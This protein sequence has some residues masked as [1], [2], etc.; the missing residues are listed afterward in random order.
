[1]NDEDNTDIDNTDNYYNPKQF[2]ANI[3]TSL[4]DFKQKF[5]SESKTRRGL[6]LVSAFFAVILGLDYFNQINLSLWFTIPLWILFVLLSLAGF[7]TDPNKTL[8]EIEKLQSIKKI[9]FSFLDVKD[10]PY[11]DKL[12]KINVENLSEYYLLVKEHT[13]QSFTLSVAV[14]GIG[15]ILI[16][17]G[18][19]IGFFKPEL[20]DISYVSTASGTII[21][22]IGGS[23]FWLYSRTV[24]QLK[25]YHDSLLDVQNILLA[26][27]LVESTTDAT[28]RSNMTQKMIDFLSS[29]RND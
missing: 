29:R 1:M 3:E 9:H 14:I 2:L 22:F 8:T 4:I 26:F 6:F 28:E 12:V 11:F 7:G 16:A 25:H 10:E 5:K 23:V 15:F 24:L 20:K 18:L 21:S 27:K 13:K 19:G 17:G